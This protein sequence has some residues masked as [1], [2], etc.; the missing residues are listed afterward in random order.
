MYNLNQ[1]FLG[2]EATDNKYL[3]RL[4]INSL[5][6]E[7]L[8]A[9]NSHELGRL[10]Y[11]YG[12]AV[13]GSFAQPNVRPLQPLKVAHAILFDQTHD[14]QSPMELRTAQD[15]LPSSALC[16]MASCAAGSN[17]GYDE[18]VPHHIHVVKETRQYANWD[19]NSVSYAF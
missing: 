12:G 8:R 6:R 3:N 2:S 13:V 7:A 18:L 10:I 17:R 19:E 5:I 4:G 1:F 14:N 11:H 9:W 16:L 15:C